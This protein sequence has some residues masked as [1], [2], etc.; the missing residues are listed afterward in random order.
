MRRPR[1]LPF[2]VSTFAALAAAAASA[3]GSRGPLDDAP[4]ADASADVTM[5]PVVTDAAPA[6]V[7]DAS[8]PE[9]APEDAGALERALE[10]ATC[11]GEEC[12]ARVAECLGNEGCRNGLLCAAT[13]CLG[14]SGGTLTCLMQCSQ[15][16]GDGSNLLLSALQCVFQTCGEDCSDVLPGGPQTP[17]GRPRRRLAEAALREAASFASNAHTER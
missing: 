12:G 13:E 3:C 10:C 8:V 9:A 11:L 4:Y 14:G 17:P 6:P 16:A 5:P 15:V 2:A 7:V 1:S